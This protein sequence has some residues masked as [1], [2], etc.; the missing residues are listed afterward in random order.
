LHHAA[1][2]EALRGQLAAG[3]AYSESISWRKVRQLLS[4]PSNWIIILQVRDRKAT[5]WFAW[6]QPLLAY[7]SVV[8]AS[9]VYFHQEAT[10]SGS[11]PFQQL[12]HH[13]AGASQALAYVCI[14]SWLRV[15]TS[16]GCTC[17][18]LFCRVLDGGRVLAGLFHGAMCCGAQSAAAAV[19]PQ[20]LDHH[21]AGASQMV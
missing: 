18:I 12:D 14:R 1:F 13:P 4:I 9:S 19:H 20:Q 11:S 7:S 21:P 8:G 15:M 17:R 6:L 3:A 10:R 2:E 5:Q 16:S